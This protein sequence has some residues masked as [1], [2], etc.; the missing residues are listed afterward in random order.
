M[1]FSR[2]GRRLASGSWSGEVMIWDA[3]TGERL[4]HPLR[5]SRTPSARW[6]SARTAGAW[7]RPASTGAWIVWD[8]TTGERLQTLRARRRPRP[9][10]RLQPG[11]LAPRLGRRGQDGARLGG[12]DRPRGARPP[13]AHRAVAGAWR[14]APTAGASPRP[15]RTG[16]SAS[17]T[18]PPCG[19]TKARRPSPSAKGPVKSGPWRSAP[20]AGASPRRASARTRR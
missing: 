20:T 10:R 17:G 3:E 4:R 7:S 15:A 12:G 6:R 13:R 9:R 5:T 14:S 1:A 8:A 16:P 18:R 11:R 2:D 19:G